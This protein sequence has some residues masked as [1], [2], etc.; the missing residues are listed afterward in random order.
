MQK[1]Y[2]QREIRPERN[3]SKPSL[4]LEWEIYFSLHCFLFN[5]YEFEL[6]DASI[7]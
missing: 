6:K 7:Y 2:I 5:T 4:V 3:V 1:E